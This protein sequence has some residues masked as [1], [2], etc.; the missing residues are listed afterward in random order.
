MCI[1][2]HYIFKEFSLDL[3][4]PQPRPTQLR[5][6]PTNDGFV[7]DVNGEE[8]G[9]KII[10]VSFVLPRDSILPKPLP[11][12]SHSAREKSPDTSILR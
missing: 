12:G 10:I 11:L 1:G 3:K 2:C 5:P 4:E 6:C 8:I 9:G 7:G